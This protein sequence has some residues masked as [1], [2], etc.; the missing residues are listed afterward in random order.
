MSL[1]L[2]LNWLASWCKETS[3][4]KLVRLHTRKNGISIM[5]Q[6]ATFFLI[7]LLLPETLGGRNTFQPLSWLHCSLLSQLFAMGEQL[8][9]QYNCSEL[10]MLRSHDF[11]WENIFLSQVLQMTLRFHFSAHS[12]QYICL[13]GEFPASYFMST[14]PYCSCHILI[15]FLCITINNRL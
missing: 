1:Y 6:E 12:T 11:Q 13:C 14:W 5:K 15:S 4:L 10:G 7:V 2:G 9:L 3:S 8:L